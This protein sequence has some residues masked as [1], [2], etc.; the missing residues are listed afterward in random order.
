M[1]TNRN[2]NVVFGM[3]EIMKEAGW[4][5]CNCDEIVNLNVSGKFHWSDTNLSP[6]QA[7]MKLLWA[8]SV[9]WVRRLR[10]ACK[11][12]CGPVRAM[13]QAATVTDVAQARVH[14]GWDLN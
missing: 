3:P 5:Y 8:A 4:A 12:S 10:D 1:D 6:F 7:Q 9:H 14:G 2:V 13:I 11:W